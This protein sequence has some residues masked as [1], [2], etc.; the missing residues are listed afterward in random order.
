MTALA[1]AISERAG[2]FD[3]AFDVAEYGADVPLRIGPLMVR[4]QRSRHYVPAWA[5]AI[6]SPD[7]LRLVYTGDTGPDE[8]AV[9]F[10]RGADLLLVEAA[11][12]TAADDDPVRGH[13]TVEEAID[14]AR[15]AGARA[16]LVVHFDPD[17]Q[18]EIEALC[19]AAGPWIRPA[20]AG[21][22]LSL[23]PSMGGEAVLAP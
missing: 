22:T 20:H 4:F 3:T 21:L 7:G 14:L 2:F 5:C 19:E 23:V 1:E 9:E 6:E 10:A 12:R 15:Q 11:L 17:R 18:A 13:L 16:A 8:A